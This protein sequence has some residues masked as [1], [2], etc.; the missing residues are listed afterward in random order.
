VN[1]VPSLEETVY[2]TFSLAKL[3]SFPVFLNIL[4]RVHFYDKSTRI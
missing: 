3:G 1:S 2:L 4:V